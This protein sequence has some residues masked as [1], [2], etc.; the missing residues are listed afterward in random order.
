MS[1][2]SG[3]HRLGPHNGTLSVHTARG[4]AAAKVGHDLTIEVTSWQATFELSSELS[5]ST[6]ELTADSTSLRV[7]KGTG[8]VQALGA[9][10]I[11]SIQKTI[12]DKVL[13]RCDIAFRSS[14]V[15]GE[16]GSLRVSGDL[17]LA[18]RTAPASFEVAITN[19]G[20]V[21]AKATVKQTDWSIKPY[22]GLLGAL[23]VKDEVE[24]R[25]EGRL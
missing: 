21:S 25:F 24:V 15:E 10:D 11:K 4:G 20:A 13:R 23:K 17:T 14:S 1:S 16:P 3:S 8:G 22:S 18:G 2:H 7:R 6:V 19:D 5:A 12:D 9:R